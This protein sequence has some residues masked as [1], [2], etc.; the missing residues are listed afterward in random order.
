M[1]SAGEIKGVG[2]TGV[3]VCEIIYPDPSRT[4]C[5]R[6]QL[7]V[8][9]SQVLVG[10]LEHY[11]DRVEDAYKLRDVDRPAAHRSY[12]DLLRLDYLLVVVECYSGGA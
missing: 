7:P 12:F 5:S 6:C 10:D 1:F 8:C 9:C 4:I 3:C 11:T 2:I